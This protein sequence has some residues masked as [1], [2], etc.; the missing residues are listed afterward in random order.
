[1]DRLLD[2]A[3]SAPLYLAQPAIADIADEAIQYNART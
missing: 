3:R 1:M 2:E